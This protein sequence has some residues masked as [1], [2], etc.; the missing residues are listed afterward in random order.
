MDVFGRLAQTDRICVGD[1]GVMERQRRALAAV[2]NWASDCLAYDETE[3][4]AY[5]TR[6]LDALDNGATVD[7]LVADIGTDI[8]RAGKPAVAGLASMVFA[9]ALNAGERLTAVR[10]LVRDRQRD[11]P[12]SRS[13]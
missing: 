10:P 4:L 7:R 5:A 1:D 12:Q 8:E 2:A 13:A 6:M 3:A 9:H 11:T